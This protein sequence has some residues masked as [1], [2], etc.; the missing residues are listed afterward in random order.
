MDDLK[1]VFCIKSDRTNCRSNRLKPKM[2]ILLTY[3][4]L[5]MSLLCYCRHVCL[6]GQK[7]R[8][9]FHFYWLMVWVTFLKRSFGSSVFA[10][11]NSHGRLHFVPLFYLFIVV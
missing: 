3:H 10:C 2:I 1:I 5:V 11:M 7:E 4:V 6:A 8:L 9:F